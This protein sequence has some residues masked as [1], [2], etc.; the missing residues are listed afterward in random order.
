MD[1]LTLLIFNLLSIII[2]CILNIRI[3]ITLKKINRRSNQNNSFSI[4]TDN[5][6][7]Y[8]NDNLTNVSIFSS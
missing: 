6:S 5:T 1:S 8:I 7:L 4:V 2:V 3:V